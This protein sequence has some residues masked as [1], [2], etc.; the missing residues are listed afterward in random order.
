M[1]CPAFMGC[2]RKC[3]PLLEEEEEVSELGRRDFP[4][5]FTFGVSTSAY[6]IEGAVSEGGR[7]MTIWDS[8]SHVQGNIYDGSTGDTACDHYHKY[9]GDVQLMADLGIDAYRFSIA[10][11]RIFPDG[12]GLLNHEGVSFYNKLINDLLQNGIEPYVTLYHWDMPQV[13]EN[14]PNIRGWLTKQ[15]VKHFAY[16][17]ETC[18]KLFGDR[19]KNWI[20]FN[21]IRSFAYDGYGTG[22]QAPG[23]CSIASQSKRKIKVGDSSREPY[24][25]AHNALL[26]HARAAKIYKT[27]YQ[28]EQKGR[29]GLAVDCKWYE[30]YTC[31]KEDNYAAQRCIEFQLGWLLD[32]VFFGDYPQ[33]MRNGAKSRLPHFTE[34]ERNDLN[35]SLDFIGLSFYTAYYAQHAGEEL[36][37]DYMW[38]ATDQ[39]AI[40]KYESPD[41]K[42]IGELLGPNDIGWIYNC[43]WALPKMLKWIE[44][45]YGKEKMRRTPIIITEN[46]TMDVELNLPISKALNDLKR[47]EYIRGTLQHLCNAI[48]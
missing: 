42:Q 28:E 13:L 15:I 44:D 41:G 48:K 37:P 8:F 27:S 33:S 45:R 39:M 46:G 7:G 47:I 32:P 38:Y 25:V 18:F 16:Y 34:E 17:A 10:W 2:A 23:R 14:D 9:K 43:P 24:I 4:S 36:N 3:S 19:V 40:V 22:K 12:M 20:T 35:G 11:A 29:I 31:T 21:E 26:S 30:P 6:Q 1:A 5:G